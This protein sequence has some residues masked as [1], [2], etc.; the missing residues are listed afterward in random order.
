MATV[1]VPHQFA[2]GEQATST[3]INTYYS[4]IQ[5]LENPPVCQLY[6]ATFQTIG[7][8]SPTAITFDGSV[9]DTYNGHSNVTNNSRYTF[10]VAGT[11]LLAGSSAW[12]GNATG[13]R[14][15]E[16]VINGTTTVPGSQ[17]ILAAIPSAGNNTNVPATTCLV[18]V[19]VN[20]YV[21]LYGV[22]TSGGNLATQT[23]SGNASTMMV[24]WVHA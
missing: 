11:Y 6:Q 4:G 20:D 9:T 23:G 1:P 16:F 12:S 7:T 19:N 2:V 8:G 3:N 17:I 22:Q 18:K 5:F 10:Q 24:Y 21:E 14:G 15:S 13:V